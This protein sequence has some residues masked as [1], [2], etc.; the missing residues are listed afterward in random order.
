V[1]EKSLLWILPLDGDVLYGWS[2]IWELEMC[3]PKWP[4]LQS[5]Y[6]SFS[7]Q[8]FEFIINGLDV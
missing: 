3:C 2:G 7:L 1:R 6:Y 8:M 4:L 5:L